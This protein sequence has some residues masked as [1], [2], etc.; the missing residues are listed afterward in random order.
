MFNQLNIIL[1]TIFSCNEALRGQLKLKKKLRQQ[2]IP[3][4]E[5][6]EQFHD[7]IL[8]HFDASDQR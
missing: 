6:P 4:N 3:E 7:Q 1:F 5:Y 8:N 2:L